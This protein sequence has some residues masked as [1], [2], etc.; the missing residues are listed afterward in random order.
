MTLQGA[1]MPR[2]SSRGTLLG[3]NYEPVRRKVHE[4]IDT[5]APT[6]GLMHEYERKLTD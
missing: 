2:A 3:S 4:R 5:C 1:V 6:T